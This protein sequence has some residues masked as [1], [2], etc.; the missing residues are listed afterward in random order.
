[1]AITKVHQDQDYTVAG[2]LCQHAHTGYESHTIASGVITPA[3]TFEVLVVSPQGSAADD[4][5]TIATSRVRKGARLLV[6]NGSGGGYPITLTTSGN[7]A[8]SLGGGAAQPVTLQPGQTVGLVYNGTSW[9]LDFD[10]PSTVLHA[11]N[12]IMAHASGWQAELT[13]YDA[14]AVGAHAVNCQVI[15]GAALL[16]SDGTG[17]PVMLSKGDAI[18]ID[19]DTGGSQLYYSITRERLEVDLSAY[20][21]D[22]FCLV[23]PTAGGYCIPIISHSGAATGVAVYCED[24]GSVGAASGVSLTADLTGAGAA[25]D[26]AVNVHPTRQWSAPVIMD[27]D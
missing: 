20:F 14:S 26:V 17:G 10:R 8:I 9:L 18:G 23:V 19:D 5:D 3:G 4:L 27:I 16:V 24:S 11:Y 15:L 25:G 22:G 1:M 21:A 7:I 6:I 13:I 12:V 2:M